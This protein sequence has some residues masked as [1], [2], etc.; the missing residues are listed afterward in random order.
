MSIAE[1]PDCL[2]VEEFMAER[3]RAQQCLCFPLPGAPRDA[4]VNTLLARN[5]LTQQIGYLDYAYNGFCKFPDE[6]IQPVYQCKSIPTFKARIFA[7]PCNP[8]VGFNVACFSVRRR[9]LW[10]CAAEAEMNPP[11]SWCP[12]MALHSMMVLASSSAWMP[13]PP[14]CSMRSHDF[15]VLLASSC[16]HP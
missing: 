6:R 5:C 7:V 1:V 13:G 11:L 2:D 3:E 4:F 10:R 12:R 16:M 15:S 14:P 9:T 8:G